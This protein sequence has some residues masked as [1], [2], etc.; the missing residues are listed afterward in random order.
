MKFLFALDSLGIGGTE[1]STLDIIS[2]FQKTSSLEVVYFYGN[3][4]LKEQYEKTGYPIYFADLK[5]KK[6]YLKGILFLIKLIRKVKPDLVVSSLAKSDLMTRIACLI[7]GTT[8]ISTFLNDTYG[9]TR[10]NEQKQKKM[11]LKFLYGFM[12]D[13]LTSFIPKFWI[14]NSKSIALSNAKVLGLKLKKI[15]VIYRG[16]DSNLFH[17]WQQPP[18]INNKMKFVFVG[19]LIERKG[20]LEMVEVFNILKDTHPNIQLDIYGEG[21]FQATLKKY[22]DHHNL[23]N[24]IKLNGSVV[25]GW[26]KIYEAHC[27]LFPS[28]YEGFSGSLVEAMMSGIPI[29]A[30]DIEMNKEAI[31]DIETGLLFKVKDKQ[32][33]LEKVF[34]MIEHY[35]DMILMGKRARKEAIERFDIN[36]IAKQYEGFLKS[37][38][39]NKVDS[40][41]LLQKGH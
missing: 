28:W 14:S 31:T 3:H 29:V 23:Q 26:K 37:V 12:L 7:T 30:S 1:K 6:S 21:D 41:Q 35:P 15:K 8:V 34:K 40:S 22:I 16:R 20:L 4:Q 2:H 39:N 17:E 32:E 33:F 24:I 38:V 10:L 18:L 25:N 19:R 27:F 9:E 5:S 11:Y 13:K 36:V